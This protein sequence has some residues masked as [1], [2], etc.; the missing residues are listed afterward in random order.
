MRRKLLFFSNKNVYNISVWY[1]YCTLVF[2]LSKL[3]NQ[4]NKQW[5]KFLKSREWERDRKREMD[6]NVLL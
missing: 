3:E 6:L 5:K 1:I 4:T 2:K